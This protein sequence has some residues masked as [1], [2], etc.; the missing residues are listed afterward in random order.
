M[1]CS[2]ISGLYFA[3]DTFIMGGNHFYGT[4]CKTFA[5]TLT[6]AVFR[7]LKT[8][9]SARLGVIVFGVSRKNR[10]EGHANEVRFL[11]HLGAISLCRRK[12]LLNLVKLLLSYTRTH[13]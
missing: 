12:S 7:L 5:N 4:A 6:P 11:S 13:T 8:A 1:A 9:S 3:N 10:I 2:W